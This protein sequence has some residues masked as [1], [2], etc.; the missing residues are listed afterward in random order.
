MSL[1]KDLANARTA[2]DKLN[3]YSDGVHAAK[4]RDATSKYYQLNAAANK[5]LDKLPAGL[6]SRMV[7]EFS[8]CLK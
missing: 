2:L 1:L 3:S 4:G 8:R 5:A 6:R 7:M